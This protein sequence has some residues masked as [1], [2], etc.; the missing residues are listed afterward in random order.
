MSMKSKITD[1]AV[2]KLGEIRI[3][4]M[5]SISQAGIELAPEAFP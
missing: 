1:G 5:K 4:N 3:R 2:E